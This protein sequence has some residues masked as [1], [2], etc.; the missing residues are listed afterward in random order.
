MDDFTIQHLQAYVDES[1][2]D[3][4]RE[5]FITYAIRALT[6][7]PALANYGWPSLYRTYRKTI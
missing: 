4:D 7:D 3:D 5:G 1:V 6:D 2:Y